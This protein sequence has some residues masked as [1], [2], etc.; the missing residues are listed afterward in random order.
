MTYLRLFQQS[1]NQKS[2][3]NQTLEVIKRCS[4]RKIR[5][6]WVPEGTDKEHQQMQT[7]LSRKQACIL[8][9]AV[10]SDMCLSGNQLDCMFASSAQKGGQGWVTGF[11]THRG[12]NRQSENQHITPSQHSVFLETNTCTTAYTIAKV[13]C[14]QG[15]LWHHLK[16]FR[17]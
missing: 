12:I 10:F 16:A 17:C 6:W 2:H 1:L 15:K 7:T 11:A 3:N 13:T 4:Q 9:R 14:Q 5:I 8:T